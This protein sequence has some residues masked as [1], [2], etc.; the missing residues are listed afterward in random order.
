MAPRFVLS[1]HQEPWTENQV[2]KAIGFDFQKARREIEATRGG[3]IWSA[4]IE[5][6]DSHWILDQAIDD[7]LE[8]INRFAHRSQYQEFWLRINEDSRDEYTKNI[9]RFLFNASS[10]L[11]ALVDHTPPAFRKDD[12][13]LNRKPGGLME[14]SNASLQRGDQG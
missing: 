5:V 14:Q 2:G 13:P 7:L 8:G 11:A 3:R 9:K 4:L 1:E 6:K 12:T 10:A